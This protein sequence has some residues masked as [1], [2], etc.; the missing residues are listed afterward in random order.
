ME[1]ARTTLRGLHNFIQ[2]IHRSQNPEEERKSVDKELAHIRMEFKTGK[3]LKGHGRRKYILKMLYIYILGYDVDFGIPIITELLTS[4]KFSDK[5]VG[6]LAISILLYE[7]HEATR[8]V[9]NTLRAE[10]IDSNPLNQCCAFNVISC[11]GNKEM[12]ETLGPDILNI[13]F[14][15]TIPTVVRKKAALTLKHLYLKNPTIIQLDTEFHDKLLKLLNNP[16]LCL[17]SCAVMVLLVIVEKDPTPWEDATSKLLNILSKLMNKDYSSEYNYHSVPSPWLQVRILRTLRYIT[18]KKGAEEN[19]LSDCV[20]SLIDTCDAKLSENT[21][22]AMFSIL[23]EIIELAPFV[24]FP[25][26]TKSKIVNMLGTYLN[27]TETNLRYLALDAMCSMCAVGCDKEVQKYLSRMIDSLREI[28][29]SVKRRALQVLFDVCDNDCC[30]KILTEL[31]RFLPVSDLAIREEVIVKICLIAEK[32]AKTPQW[33]VD[34]MLQLTAVSGDYIGDQILNRILRIIINNDSVQ[35]FAAKATYKYLQEVAW[36][37]AF[38]KI[39]SYILGEYGSLVVKDNMKIAQNIFDMLKDKYPLVSYQTQLTMLSAFAKLHATFPCLRDQ[40]KSLFIKYSSSSD[41]EISD[42][43]QDYLFMTSIEELEPI[44]FEAIPPWEGAQEGEDGKIVDGEVTVT[45]N[46]ADVVSRNTKETN[47]DDDLFMLLGVVDPNKKEEVQKNN[48]LFNILTTPVSSNQQPTSS[49]LNQPTQQQPSNQSNDVFDFGGSDMNQI[50][51]QP[52]EEEVN[53]KPSENTEKYDGCIC[54]NIKE[55][56]ENVMINNHNKLILAF[57]GVLYQDDTIQIGLKSA[58]ESPMCKFALFFGNRITEEVELNYIIECPNGLTCNS[59]EYNGKIGAKSQ[60]QSIAQFTI[61]G[62]YYQSP[63]I[64]ITYK[65]S[66]F[67]NKIAFSLP[68]TVN[69]FLV[70]EPLEPNIFMQ[71]WNTIGNATEKKSIIQMKQNN[72]IDLPT[73]LGGMRFICLDVK[74][75]Q[76]VACSSFPSFQNIYVLLRIEINVTSNKACIYVR[77]QDPSLAKVIH[78]LLC[79]EIAA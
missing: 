63:I 31:L 55:Q 38:I 5:Q 30:N 8:L 62:F 76:I 61:S 46:S 15:N 37:D 77:A 4:P 58:L 40:I 22:N 41:A 25:E 28:D 45:E 53:I 7:E 9:I 44:V 75:E 27:A 50:Q 71:Y 20:K 21:R 43:C 56:M 26:N 10:L 36:K 67:K 19:Y 78:N 74:P 6:Y 59:G 32:F 72:P 11:I 23:F 1:L 34:I 49:P 14:S 35:V 68:L 33:Y 18:P 42:R 57:E 73:V 60:I 17:V 13:L 54:H 79:Y 66:S 12:V 39:S 65:S 70:Q 64:N 16:D 51:Q 24:E 69:A 47:R 52:K 48:D 3:K 2:E 29:I